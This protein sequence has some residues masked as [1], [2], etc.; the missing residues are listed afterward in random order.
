[1]GRGVN[2]RDAPQVTRIICRRNGRFTIL[3]AANKGA[4]DDNQ[5][6]AFRRAAAL[7]IRSSMHSYSQQ[8]ARC[9]L[10]TSADSEAVLV[11]ESISLEHKMQS[12]VHKIKI[13]R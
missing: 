13:C 10:T 8:S 5:Q 2:P 7:A 4:S 11:A 1:M 9:H 6:P 3:A 12:L